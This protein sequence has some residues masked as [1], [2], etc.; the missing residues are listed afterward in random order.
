MAMVS[1]SGSEYIVE[2]IPFGAK[3]CDACGKLC[4]CARRVIKKHDKSSLTHVCYKCSGGHWKKALKIAIGIIS[5][6]PEATKDD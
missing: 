6:K 1:I 3:R 5:T 4:G 2:S